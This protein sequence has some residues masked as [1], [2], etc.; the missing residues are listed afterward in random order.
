MDDDSSKAII[1]G[2]NEIVMG[3]VAQVHNLTIV[4]KNQGHLSKIIDIVLL[5]LYIIGE[6][7]TVQ[8]N[9]TNFISAT[10]ITPNLNNICDGA[11]SLRFD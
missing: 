11:V 5:G 3:Q 2:S 10:K 1:E 9:S 7:D 6:H 8:L 4:G